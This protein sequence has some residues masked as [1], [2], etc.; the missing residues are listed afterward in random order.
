MDLES[1]KAKAEN[2]GKRMKLGEIGVLFPR[3]HA[4]R[5]ALRASPL[6]LRLAMPS[7]WKYRCAFICCASMYGVASEIAIKRLA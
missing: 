2:T 5:S 1:L 4:A 7:R 6:S 3:P